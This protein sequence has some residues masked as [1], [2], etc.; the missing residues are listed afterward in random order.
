MSIKEIITI[1]V[2]A[3]VALFP[4]VN[5]IGSAFIIDGFL[6]DLNAE[7][8]KSAAKKI[9]IHS[10]LIAIVT[11]LLGHFILLLFGLAIPVVQVG[12]GIVICKTGMEWLSGSGTTSETDEKLKHKMSMAEVERKLFYPISFP[13]VIGAGSIS[14]IFTLMANKAV[15]GNVLYSGINYSIIALVICM[16]LAI[17]YI[18]L[19]QG[20]KLVE[21]LGESGN[22]VINK[23]IAF[24]TFCIGIQIFVTGVSKIFHIPIL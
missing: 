9:I 1:F 23:L 2:T 24:I 16:M 15:E 3:F 22:L 11:L 19:V 8:R 5:P 18:F 14:V 17:L 7:Q 10:F 21:K 4:L 6:K 12:G 13:I 20:H